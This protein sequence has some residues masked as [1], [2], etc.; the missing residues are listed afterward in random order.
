M[1]TTAAGTEIISPRWPHHLFQE[2][3]VVASK[4]A[5]MVLRIVDFTFVYN[6]MKESYINTKWLD[7]SQAL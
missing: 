3:P 7:P 2:F 4:E 5:R 6:E 1:W